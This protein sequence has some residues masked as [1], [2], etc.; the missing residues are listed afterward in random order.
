MGSKKL[1]D[2]Q[3]L[4]ISINHLKHQ[5]DKLKL[6]IDNCKL[7]LINNINTTNIK[8]KLEIYQFMY[9]SMIKR[10][11]HLIEHYNKL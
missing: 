9:K 6:K 5:S 8:M 1:N 10:L 3:Q 2:K 7:M 11:N 4:L